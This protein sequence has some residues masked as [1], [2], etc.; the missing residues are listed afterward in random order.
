LSYA[1]FTAD[2][3]LRNCLL[4]AE[5]FFVRLIAR[6]ENA[7]GSFFAR[8]AIHDLGD[9]VQSP[10]GAANRETIPITG[11]FRI[12]IRKPKAF[13]TGLSWQTSLAAK[14]CGEYLAGMNYQPL[15]STRRSPRHSGCRRQWARPLRRTP[16]K[17]N[18]YSVVWISWLY[19][20]LTVVNENRQKPRRPFRKSLAR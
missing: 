17:P 18:P 14:S 4:S 5:N 19:F 7:P 9:Q 3:V 8:H 11:T 20:L 6:H 1:T 10:S 2:F 12:G 13:I 15:G 16:S